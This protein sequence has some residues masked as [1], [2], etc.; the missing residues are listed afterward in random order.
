ML[1]DALLELGSGYSGYNQSFPVLITQLFVSALKVLVFKHVEGKVRI[2]GEDSDEDSGEGSSSEEEEE[3]EVVV[4]R[5]KD[6]LKA[7]TPKEVDKRFLQMSYF[8]DIISPLTWPDVLIHYI[9]TQ[10]SYY[11]QVKERQ[12]QTV[13]DV[14]GSIVCNVVEDDEDYGSDSDDDMVDVTI[15][16]S[17]GANSAN[18]A[19][20]A[21]S[22]NAPSNSKKEDDELEGGY[23]GKTNSPS[24]K[25]YMKLKKQ[26][27]WCLSSKECLGLL[28]VLADDLLS[29]CLHEE[30]GRRADVLEGLE[31]AKKKAEFM[32]VRVKNAF[33]RANGEVK[34]KQSD[35][36]VDESKNKKGA[37]KGEEEEEKK[38]KNVKTA[39]DVEDAEEEVRLKTKE[40]MKGMKSNLYRQRDL[41]LDRDFNKYWSFYS[42]SSYIF[43]EKGSAG[44]SNGN[45]D[46]WYFLNT[47][48]EYDQ[49]VASLD[50]RGER[51]GALLENLQAYCIRSGLVDD[52]K[53]EREAAVRQAEEAKLR[54]K[55]SDAIEAAEL[56]KALDEA[57]GRR[58]TRVKTE[59]N[60]SDPVGE[61]KAQ[62]DRHL[63]AAS[64]VKSER[65]LTPEELRLKRT[66]VI[67]CLEFDNN[68]REKKPHEVSK[69]GAGELNTEMKTTMMMNKGFSGVSCIVE[70]I[71]HAEVE[72]ELFSSTGDAKARAAW[73]QRLTEITK[74]YEEKLAAGL[75][76][77]SKN[78]T[79]YVKRLKEPL[80]DL[81]QR[82]FDVIGMAFFSDCE[83]QCAKMVLEEEEEDSDDEDEDGT[84]SQQGSQTGPAAATSGDADWMEE[85][86][87]ALQFL[88]ESALAVSC[89]LQVKDRNSWR[90]QVKS[91]DTVA[92][93]GSLLFGFLREFGDYLFAMNEG[94]DEAIKVLQ[95][96]GKSESEVSKMDKAS[97]GKAVVRRE[98]IKMRLES[99]PVR[100]KLWWAKVNK[101]MPWWPCHEHEVTDVDVSKLLKK[102]DLTVVSM[103]GGMVD[104]QEGQKGSEGGELLLVAKERVVDMWEQDEE[105]KWAMIP[106]PDA[107]EELDAEEA[108]AAAAKKQR[109]QK[110]QGW[111]RPRAH[112]GE[113]GEFDDK[114]TKARELATL[115]AKK[116][117]INYAK[118][119]AKIEKEKGKEGK[120]AKSGKK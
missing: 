83:D 44:G 69:F 120:E 106:D 114:M 54:K 103:V 11:A 2:A 13:R 87:E 68:Y 28:R 71:L 88:S 35:V 38:E 93:I 53:E 20:R 14:R 74:D 110:S 64:F 48:S 107:P 4:Q 99:E 5:K 7:S 47:M 101:Y 118:Q 86:E 31:K 3:E 98:G 104:G 109:K 58:S 76:E 97:G 17:A 82:M 49:L 89:S 26:E 41:G 8:E 90:Q 105:G 117:M 39:Q 67:A 73:R 46:E 61:L 116:L 70:E 57:A 23:L 72:I 63:K 25:G 12:E 1:S 111:G 92:K 27:P 56:K 15:D 78:V 30:F 9:D 91:A 18:S 119:L 22:A 113:G 32:L 29:K 100:N 108:A 50:S 65:V 40:F 94:R 52:K 21:S 16:A 6:R 112:K 36:G 34:E 80:L 37:K 66:G 79:A 43:V 75:E 62:L 77:N 60:N 102:N 33:E 45:E 51:E 42:A 59:T 96:W 19:N 24:Y 115:K 95:G 85:E 84:L 55:L 10:Q 81:E